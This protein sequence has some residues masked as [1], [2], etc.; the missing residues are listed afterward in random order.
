MPNKDH[1]K[2][3]KLSFD[4]DGTLRDVIDNFITE[5]EESNG[6]SFSDSGE[7]VKNFRENVVISIHT[8]KKQQIQ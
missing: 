3:Q 2:V 7:T 8:R 5:K 1:R 6:K 4:E